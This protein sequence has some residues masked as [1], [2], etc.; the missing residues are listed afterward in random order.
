MDGHV[1]TWNITDA[2]HRLGEVIRLARAEGPQRITVRGETA[3]YVLP[4]EL[5]RASLGLE[6]EAPDES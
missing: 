1:R 3:A 4:I 5:Y 2:K 6:R